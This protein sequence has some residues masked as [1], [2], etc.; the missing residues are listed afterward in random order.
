ME[1]LESV[2]RGR[3]MEGTYAW[4]SAVSATTRKPWTFNV[5]GDGADINAWRSLE[6]SPDP[7]LIANSLPLLNISW[8]DNASPPA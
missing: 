8:D 7:S 2:R 3:F 1:F 5:C 4:I 6:S